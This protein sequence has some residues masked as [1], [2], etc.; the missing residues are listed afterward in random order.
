MPRYLLLIFILLHVYTSTNAMAPLSDDS[1]LYTELALLQEGTGDVMPQSE[2][3]QEIISE[4][5]GPSDLALFFGRFHP[6]LVHLPI[7]FLLFAF[8]L[9]GVSRIKKYEQLNFAVP[10]ALLLG[11][12]SGIAASITGYLL[13]SGGGYGE[14]LLDM[15]KWMGITVTVLSLLAFVI[16]IKFFENFVLKKVYEMAMIFMAGILLVTGHYGGSLTHGS[17]YLYR[18]MPEPVRTAMGLHIQKEED[19]IEL[20]Q[21]LDSALVYQDVIE[22]ILR[23]RC[24]SCHNQDRKE[25]ELLMASFDEVMAGG[26]SGPIIVTHQA[27]ESELYKRLILPARDEN[28]MPPRGRRQLTSDQ[29]NLIAWWIDQ[30]AP[31]LSRVSELE[32]SGNISGALDK[33]TKKGQSF[34]ATTQV[35]KADA[36]VLENLTEHGFNI[37]PIAENTNFLNAGLSQSMNSISSEDMDLLIPLSKQITWLDLSRSGAT[38]STLTR[39]SHFNNLTRLNLAGTPI[40]DRTIETISMLKNLEY[41]NVYN[42]DIG[43]GGIKQ[44]KTHVNMKSLYLWQTKVSSE[45]IDDLKANLPELYINIGWKSMEKGDS[46][47]ADMLR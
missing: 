9:E 46:V 43:D 42:T 2:S 41:L 6:I 27:E 13:S 34:F 44:L 40:G 17:D 21:D 4:P 19:T 32:V 36:L 16:R 24:Q 45:G 30:G 29:I 3:D 10:F 28:R 39:L 11:G 15:H 31:S 37:S 25:G 14:D 23:T 35:S 33:L 8:L 38:D 1:D 12:I 20:I 5:E 7:G 47:E 18:Y 26:E 22:P